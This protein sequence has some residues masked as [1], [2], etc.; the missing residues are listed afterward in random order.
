[1]RNVNNNMHTIKFEILKELKEK[2]QKQVKHLVNHEIYTYFT[3]RQ[4][5]TEKS[6]A[7]I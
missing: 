1:M 6:S 5:E 7:C 2:H 4:Q 3:E